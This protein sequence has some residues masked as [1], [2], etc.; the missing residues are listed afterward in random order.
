MSYFDE[1]HNTAVGKLLLPVS[2]TEKVLRTYLA[3]EAAGD[4]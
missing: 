4:D 3:T 2:S 1:Y